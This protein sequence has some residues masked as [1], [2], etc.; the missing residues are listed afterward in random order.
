MKVRPV[1]GEMFIADTQTDRRADMTKLI[2][3]FRSFANA[4]NKA[5]SSDSLERE[6]I[7]GKSTSAT[8]CIVWR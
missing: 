1:G 7:L 4:P 3:A 8:R 5:V 6:Y 2:V